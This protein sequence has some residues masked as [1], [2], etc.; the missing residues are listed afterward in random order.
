MELSLSPVEIANI[1]EA[2]EIRGQTA[3]TVRGIAALES[4]QSGDLS[5]LGNPKYKTQ[6]ATTQASVVLLPLDYPGEP[7]PDQQFLLLAKPSL[8]LSR[9]CAHIETMLWPKPAPGIHPSAII[10]PSAQVASSATIGPF[11]IVESGAR[12][13]ERCHLEANIFIGRDVEMSDD[14]WL[15]PGV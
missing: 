3:A 13:G 6:V 14:C 8:G 1:V 11:C 7:K 5:F 4:A 15:M 10:A 12:I 2:K 9:L